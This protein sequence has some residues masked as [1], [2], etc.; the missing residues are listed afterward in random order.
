V[1]SQDTAYWTHMPNSLWLG[2]ASL[3][4]VLCLVPP[5]PGQ[6]AGQVTLGGKYDRLLPEQKALIERWIREVYRITGERVDAEPSYNQL[7]L[8]SRTTFEAVTHALIQSKLTDPSGKPIGK[9]IDL[10]DVVERIAG[11]VP[12]TRGD[13]QFRVYVYLKRDALDKLYLSREFQREHDNAVYHIGY[14]LSFR[15][16]GGAPSVQFSAT[17][18]GYR[19]D[20][21]VD[22][23]SSSKA[24][25]LFNGHLT[26][27]NSD[28]RA[29]NNFNTHNR[30]WND[31]PNWWQAILASMFG[32]DTEKADLDTQDQADGPIVPPVRADWEKA[33]EGEVQDAVHGFL[34]EWLVVGDPARLLRGISVKA[35][36]CVAEF[37]D[38]SRPD[39]KLALYRIL[40]QMKRVKTQ[41]GKINELTE[42]IEPVNYPLPG[43][44]P[45]NHP[46][47][48]LFSLQMVPDDVAWAL[49]CRVRYGLK[50]AENVPQPAHK[51]GSVYASAWRFRK[52]PPNVF[53]LHFWRR[54]GKE[55]RV[56]S[57]DIKHHRT[58]PPADIVARTASATGGIAASRTPS[59]ASG[60]NAGTQVQ[61]A[62]VKLMDT[63]L[64]QKKPEDALRWFA[65]SSYAC[66]DLTEGPVAPAARSGEAGRARLLK[67]LKEI[68][69]E[70][71]PASRLEDVAAA[72]ESGHPHLR[73]IAHERAGAFLLN[74]V[75][76]DIVRMYAC[77][78]DGK[79][80]RIPRNEGQGPGTYTLGAYMTASRSAKA[81]GDSP[82]VL[83][84]FW[85]KRGGEWR[86]VSYA[87]ADD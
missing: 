44:T 53:R 59:A 1:S 77:P 19:A 71:G 51:S 35:Y 60:A 82:A 79:H 3:T 18:T 38:G 87:L 27:A 56:V 68:S 22:Y 84:L 25:F 57:F 45:V 20:I 34:E 48:N 85:E 11:R 24:K 2:V 67:A 42:A 21:D 36:P 10:V 40:Q 73:P 78:S 74:R 69:S 62:A 58:P 46:Y 8:S 81:E 30:R 6:T 66:D 28:V 43:A 63:W 29:G 4:A 86:V 5:A 70:V 76:D 7:P 83:L 72:P 52:D 47:A 23:R 32:G 33:A 39:S 64:V 50:L 55:W 13:Y 41:I 54:Q 49:D 9:A 17:R 15:Q 80:K 37:R 65:P 26:A 16:Q 31:L 12:G 14:P 61:A 75:S